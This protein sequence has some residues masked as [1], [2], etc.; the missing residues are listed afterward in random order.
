M[1]R[2]LADVL[3]RKKGGSLK[4]FSK[5]DDRIR[6]IVDGSAAIIAGSLIGFDE[7]ISSSGLFEAFVQC[8]YEP[9]MAP[10][11]LQACILP[12]YLLQ[13]LIRSL[14]LQIC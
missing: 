5:A 7:V 8:H 11:I 14:R 10:K 9:I 6:D 12:T 4:C 1:P 3:Q 2:Q 13:P